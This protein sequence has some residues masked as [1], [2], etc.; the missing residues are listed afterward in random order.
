MISE[1]LKQ[2]VTEARRILLNQAR[3]K[4]K[5]NAMEK[6]CNCENHS[7]VIEPTKSTSTINSIDVKSNEIISDISNYQLKVIPSVSQDKP[8]EMVNNQIELKDHITISAKLTM[9]EREVF[10]KLVIYASNKSGHVITNTTLIKAL[11]RLGNLHKEQIF[12]E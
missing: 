9:G 4:I 10:D 12:I 6:K 3:N 8:K 5:D 2:R 7:K 11:I 1:I